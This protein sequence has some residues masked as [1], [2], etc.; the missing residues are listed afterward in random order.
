[1]TTVVW[2]P[3]VATKLWDDAWRE[4]AT[5]FMSWP[6]IGQTILTIERFLLTRVLR[7]FGRQQDISQ[8]YCPYARFSDEEKKGWRARLDPGRCTIESR[9]P[10]TRWDY[11]VDVTNAGVTPTY[12][13]QLIV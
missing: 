4:L 2:R 3:W 9:I 5:M 10:P 1:M 12:R 6:L 13:D 8:E 7:Q 11:M